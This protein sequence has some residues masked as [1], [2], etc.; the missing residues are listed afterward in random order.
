MPGQFIGQ[1][2]LRGDTN[3]EYLD[4]RLSKY[5]KSY[6]T[7]YKYQFPV[8]QIEQILGPIEFQGKFFSRELAFMNK[9][10]EDSYESTP[11]FNITKLYDVIHPKSLLAKVLFD[12]NPNKTVSLIKYYSSYTYMQRNLKAFSKVWTY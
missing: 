3:Y 11:E 2:K 7:I 6:N 10:V 12:N 8:E 5:D 4:Y 1:Q 9:L